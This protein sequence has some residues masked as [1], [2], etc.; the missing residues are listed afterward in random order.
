MAEGLTREW[1]I[2]WQVLAFAVTIIAQTWWIGSKIGTMDSEIINL[3]RRMNTIEAIGSPQIG[4][5]KS[6]LAVDNRRLQTL[7]DLVYTKIPEAVGLNARQ[8]ERISQATRDINA[9][10][11]WQ[12]EQMSFIQEVLL[13][14]RELGVEVTALKEQVSRLQNKVEMLHAP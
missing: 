7:E 10:Q 6:D 4:A 2:P 11:S 9:I 12:K 1:S 5:I 3:D 14:H 8:D 13:R